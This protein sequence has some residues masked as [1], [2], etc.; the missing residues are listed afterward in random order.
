MNGYTFNGYEVKIGQKW[1]H[2]VYET[3]EV[4]II[5]ITSD[6][7]PVVEDKDGYISKLISTD[8][9]LVP[10]TKEIEVV[11]VKG[12][13]TGNTYIDYLE[14]AKNDHMLEIISNPVK[15]KFELK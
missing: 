1:Y 6:G 10:E 12:K 14:K 4:T 5:G 7:F 2:Q 9:K 15:V 13:H 11:L 8:Y 3:E